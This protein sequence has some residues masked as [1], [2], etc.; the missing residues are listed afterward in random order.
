MGFLRLFGIWA[1]SIL[2]AGR[3]VLPAL[4]RPAKASVERHQL[5]GLT[6]RSTHLLP[7]AARA[8]LFVF[9]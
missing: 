1:Q 6:I 2:R 3:R 8:A 5:T 4:N 7:N 9:A